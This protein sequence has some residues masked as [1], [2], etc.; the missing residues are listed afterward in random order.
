MSDDEQVESRWSRSSRR[1]SSSPSVPRTTRSRSAGPRTGQV[2][3]ADDEA[4]T[5]TSRATSWASTRS[6]AAWSSTARSRAS[7][8]EVLADPPAGGRRGSEAAPSAP[9]P[10]LEKVQ[11]VERTRAIAS[12]SFTPASSSASSRARRPGR[13][14]PRFPRRRRRARAAGAEQEV[15]PDRGL[16][17]EPSEKLELR[18]AERAILAHDR[19]PRGRRAP[20]RRG[21]AGRRRCSTARSPSTR[22]RSAEKRGSDVRSSTTSGCR[23]TSAKP[24]IPVLDGNRAPT[25]V[26]PPCPE[27]AS[28]TSSSASSS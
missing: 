1:T 4:R 17:G 14:S 13:P 6:S 26:S 22:A 28:K 9:F 23:V 27:T 21:G 7:S 24:A 18:D 5:T 20:A 11:R 2:E 3:L 15:E 16:G 8:A 19:A 10:F 12:S 25:S